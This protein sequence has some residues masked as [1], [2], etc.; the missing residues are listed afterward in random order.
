MP[1]SPSPELVAKPLPL[2]RERRTWFEAA[3]ARLDERRLTDFLVELTGIHSPTG[4]ER[5]ASEWVVGELS[6]SGFEAELQPMGEARGNAIGRLRGTGD[7]ATLLLYEPI[8]T[9]MEATEEDDLPWAGPELRPDMLPR[10]FARDGLV[11]GLGAS[12]PKAMVATVTEVARAIRDAEVPLM[13]DLVLGFAG[14]GMPWSNSKRGHAGLSDGVAHLLRHGVSPDFAL[15]MKPWNAVYFEEAGLCWFRVDVKGTYGYAGIPHGTPGWNQS[16]VP[17]ATVILELQEWL[18]QYVEENTSGQIEPW[19]WISSVRGGWPDK[20]AFPTALTEIFLDLRIT[21]R[22]S[23][24]EVSRQFGVAI[25]TVRDK[26]PGIDL[27]WELIA[28]TPTGSTDPENWIVQSALRGW[29]DVEGKPHGAAPRMA[30]QTDGAAL[31]HLGI[32]TARVGWPWP[33]EGGP[34]ELKE[35]LG[36]MGVTYVPDLL[37]CAKK[38][39]YVVVDTLTRGRGELGL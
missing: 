16:V 9:H 31:R 25:A 32:P 24:Q 33:Y 11:I 26:H 15:V 6:R 10:G 18:R 36:G 7:G 29:E 19:G 5:A 37:S 2:D 1:P 21:P 39:L 22:T 38:I 14:G 30:G 3:C 35:G 27:D 12:N 20:P 28:A 8:D 23:P 13:G 17:A 4:S 34:P